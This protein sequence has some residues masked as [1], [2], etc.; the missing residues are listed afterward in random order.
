MNLPSMSRR[1]VKKTR[2][3]LNLEHLTAAQ[4][5]LD[6]V[7]PD[8]LTHSSRRQLELAVWELGRVYAAVRDG[9]KR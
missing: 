8:S 5:R 2:Q 3:Q 9:V 4:E 6:L 7:P 1:R